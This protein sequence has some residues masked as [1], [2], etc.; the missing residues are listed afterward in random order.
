MT[1]EEAEIEKIL[2]EKKNI[3][4]ERAIKENA[5]RRWWHRA[6][7]SGV[8]FGVTALGVMIFL[9]NISYSQLKEANQLE[10]ERREFK[11]EQTLLELEELE[12]IVAEKEMLLNE[13]QEELERLTAILNNATHLNETNSTDQVAKDKEIVLDTE[14]IAGLQNQI[15][16]SNK[17]LKK[18]DEHLE[19]FNRKSKTLNRR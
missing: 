9:Y 18:A 17:M 10:I 16:Q 1:K 2:A 7:I 8:T 12:D 6:V 5:A 19:E 15:Q 4:S 14:E 13:R 3:E 11:N